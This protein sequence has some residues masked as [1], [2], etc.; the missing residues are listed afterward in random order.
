MDDH[1]IGPKG[2]FGTIL[3]PQVM[4]GVQNSG[5]HGTPITQTTVK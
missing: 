1:V 2:W 5:L 3:D 4:R